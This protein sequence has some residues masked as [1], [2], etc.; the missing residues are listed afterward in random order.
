MIS[1]FEI[2]QTTYNL[3]LIAVLAGLAL[4]VVSF[5]R[6]KA[7]ARAARL[8]AIHLVK[9]PKK[10]AEGTEPATPEADARP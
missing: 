2:G 6:S 4:F 7:K 5:V 3:P 10:K 8:Q 9:I 1:T